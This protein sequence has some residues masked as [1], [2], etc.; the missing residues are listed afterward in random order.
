M[1]NYSF[2]IFTHSHPPFSID[3]SQWSA[4]FGAQRT[5]HHP[6][7][8][9]FLKTSFKNPSRIKS[10]QARYGLYDAWSSAWHFSSQTVFLMWAARWALSCK[11]QLSSLIYVNPWLQFSVRYITV[12]SSAYSGVCF[13]GHNGR[14]ISNL[15]QW[16]SSRALHSFTAPTDH[17]W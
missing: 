7:T 1:H 11:R 6:Q 8:A 5:S 2:I 14:S 15:Q 9:K 12:S 16:C 3:L 13:L 17:R 10:E 4:N